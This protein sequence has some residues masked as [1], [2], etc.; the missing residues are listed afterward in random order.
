MQY[1]IKHLREPDI[2]SKKTP[3]EWESQYIWAEHGMSELSIFGYSF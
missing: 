3:E 2:S 1:F